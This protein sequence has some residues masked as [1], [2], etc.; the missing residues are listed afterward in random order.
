MGRLR[1]LPLM[2]TLLL[3]AGCGG[4]K[5][6][7]AEELAVE[8]QRQWQNMTA[9]AG[10]MDLTADYGERVFSCG[11]DVTYDQV[12]GGVLTLTEPEL[13]R[14]ICA[15]LKPDGLTL[16]YDGVSLETGPLTE[17]GLSPLEAAPTFYQQLTQ[18]SLAAWDLTD[19]ALSLTFRGHD[20]L[21]GEG[22]EATLTFSRETNQPL[23]GELY[24][25][26]AQI[27]QAQFRDFQMMTGEAPEER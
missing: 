2:M 19:E 22:L 23:T 18:G 6:A 21:P 20:A 11:L 10:H 1:L 14:G 13:V 9:C 25:N 27:I 7:S 26:G 8:L 12:T 15:Y 24:W 5:E 16:R 4:Q 3:L 17:E